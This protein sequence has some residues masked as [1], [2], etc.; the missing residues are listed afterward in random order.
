MAMRDVDSSDME[1]WTVEQV[2]RKLNL[3][4]ATVWRR[5]YSGDLE[6]VKDGRS[7]RVPPAAVAAYIQGLRNPAATEKAAS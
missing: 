2:A 7:R 1:L 3:S 5:I 6:S 4:K